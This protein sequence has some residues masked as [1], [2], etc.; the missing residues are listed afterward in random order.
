M[1]LNE[2]SR[3]SAFTLIELL[4][5]IAIIAILAAILLPALAAAKKKSQQTYCLNSLKQLG[6]G[7]VLYVGEYND[8]MPADASHSAGWHAEDWIYWWGNWNASTLPPAGSSFSPPLAQS[9]ISQMIKYSNTNLVNTVF[10]CPADTSDKGRIANTGWTPIYE[11]SYSINGMGDPTG[12]PPTTGFASMWDGPNNSW[13]PYKYTRPLQPS[14][15]IMLVEEPTDVT[16][17]EQQP[18]NTYK[19]IDDGRWEPGPNGVTVRHN[20]R[21]NVAYADGHAERVT[22]PYALLPQHNDPSQ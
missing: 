13:V 11:Y 3:P 1:K 7:F 4:V 16:S 12:T 6:L 5:V 21:G 18:A 20:T 17:L 2:N 10:R 14:S 15:L 8:T 9:P 22:T 19:I